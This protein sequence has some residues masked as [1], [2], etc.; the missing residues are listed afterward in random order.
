MAQAARATDAQIASQYPAREAIER[1]ERLFGYSH[2]EAVR[3]IGDQR[4]DGKHVPA[5]VFRLP[6]TNLE[7]A[8]ERITD[9]HWTLIKDEKEALGYDREA[10]EHSLQL[11]SVFKGQSASIPVAGSEMLLFRLGGLLKTAEKVQQV[12]GLEKLPAVREGRSEMG[13]VKF[14]AV[15]KE[16]QKKLEEWLTQ[17][18]VLHS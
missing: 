18:S 6:Y 1:W 12:A 10:Y 13:V 4:G 11:P 8:R 3:L 17:Q 2:M 15:D 7:V 14:C 16:A 9:E 5:Q